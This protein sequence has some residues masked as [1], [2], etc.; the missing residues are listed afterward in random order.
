[1]SLI[2]VISAECAL[3][4]ANPCGQVS[5]GVVVLYGLVMQTRLRISA[6]VPNG[7]EGDLKY[8]LD[9]G[10]DE[11]DVEMVYSPDVPLSEGTV[12]SE[13]TVQRSR[14]EPGK[15]RPAVDA[16]VWC[17]FLA[18]RPP[19]FR[20]GPVD[21]ILMLLGRSN[22]VVGAFERL[23]LVE[24]QVHGDDLAEGMTPSEAVIV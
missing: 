17:L 15:P 4:T 21:W 2:R 3:A 10:R 20:G 5:D 11:A 24:A 22:T 7:N 23:G 13:T 14:L 9:L 6:L 12:G 8:D 16:E 19:K 1:M 18:R